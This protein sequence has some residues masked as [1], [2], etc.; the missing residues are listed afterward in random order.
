M[1]IWK[2]RRKRTGEA[3]QARTH[4]GFGNEAISLPATLHRFY[5]LPFLTS[6]SLFSLSLSLSCVRQ[7]SSTVEFLRSQARKGN[8]PRDN[9]RNPPRETPFEEEDREGKQKKKE[10]DREKKEERGTSRGERRKPAKRQESEMLAISASVH[11]VQRR[12]ETCNAAAA[13]VSRRRA[14]ARMRETHRVEAR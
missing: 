1:P 8:F 13:I 2:K 11:G 12:R 6:A 9:D 7:Q 14:H 4:S 10:R 5:S 3:N